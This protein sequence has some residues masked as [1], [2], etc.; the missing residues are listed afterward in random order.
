MKFKILAV[1][2]FLS[3]LLNAAGIVFTVL[4]FDAR[5]DIKKMKKE[6]SRVEH[7]MMLAAQAAANAKYTDEHTKQPPPSPV[8]VKE[9]AERI[10]V[11]NFTSLVDG[12]Q[13]EIGIQEPKAGANQATILIVY[14]HGMGANYMQPFL[15]PSDVPVAR[16]FESVEPNTCVLS[17]NYRKE[18]SWGNDLA[19]A[20]VT[21]N[22]RHVMQEMPIHRIVL[23]GG[24][25]G[26]CSA[27][28]YAIQA[29]VDIRDKL[30]GVISV[31]GA[32]DLVQLY[33]TTALEAIRICMRE[34]L[35]GTPDQV[36]GVYLAKSLNHNLDKVPA[37]LRFAIVTTDQDT[38]V[39]SALQ[40]AIADQLKAKNLKVEQIKLNGNHSP[41]AWPAYAA[42]YKFILGR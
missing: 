1:L 3:L 39:P 34:A 11:R 18:S 42:A 15:Y 14:F 5:G 20:D 25:M 2:L 37:H 19:V 7:N 24:S 33:R 16:A 26:G 10:V 31:Q 41:P 22:I 6:K 32:S 13:D 30:I 38:I 8:I 17:V 4:Y 21:Q 29:P 27:M 23:A 35:G 36:A 40:Y 9:M 28:G 12:V